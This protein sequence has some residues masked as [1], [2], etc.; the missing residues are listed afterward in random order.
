MSDLWH[1]RT[2]A[3]MVL[4]AV[5]FRPGQRRAKRSPLIGS[6]ALLDKGKGRPSQTVAQ[7]GDI[8]DGRRHAK[9]E[10]GDTHYED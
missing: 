7:A 9:I 2:I 10:C 5:A 4:L 8:D 6:G 3:N 1:L